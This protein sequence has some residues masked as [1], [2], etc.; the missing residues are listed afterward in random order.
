MASLIKMNQKFLSK[1][2]WN[3]RGGATANNQ[4]NTPINIAATRKK[5]IGND[6]LKKM[7]IERQQSIA[8]SSSNSTSI[9]DLNSSHGSS[10]LANQLNQ[11]GDSNKLKR[12]KG[13]SYSVTDL[14][15]LSEKPDFNWLEVSDGFQQEIKERRHE[16]YI[17]EIEMDG[18]LHTGPTL[19]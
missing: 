13:M 3:I 4:R 19:R 7:A 5:F 14:R 2:S 16:M 17:A 10:G 9:N 6:K 18:V 8:S 12:S 1:S 15:E 11:S